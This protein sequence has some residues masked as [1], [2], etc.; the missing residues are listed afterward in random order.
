[1]AGLFFRSFGS[2]SCPRLLNLFEDAC[3]E[4]IQVKCWKD[5]LR[6]SSF[7]L[8]KMFFCYKYFSYSIFFVG[9]RVMYVSVKKKKSDACFKILRCHFYHFHTQSSVALELPTSSKSG[10]TD[11]LLFFLGLASSWTLRSHTNSGW[12]NAW[13]CRFID[14][15]CW[16]LS[17]KRSI[18]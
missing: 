16:Q 5:R 14:R 13:A 9:P 7:S 3:P 1:M 2:M 8:V 6:N 4:A 17:C 12:S 10:L 11:L 15:W 18:S